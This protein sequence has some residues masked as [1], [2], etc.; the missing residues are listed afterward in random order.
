[1]LFSVTFHPWWRDS[2]GPLDVVLYRSMVQV[3]ARFLLAKHR[4]FVHEMFLDGLMNEKVRPAAANPVVSRAPRPP[5]P[6]AKR[7]AAVSCAYPD[8]QLYRIPRLLAGERQGCR[9]PARPFTR[10]HAASAI[11]V[12]GGR[13][14]D[15]AACACAGRH[16]PA[17]VARWRGFSWAGGWCCFSSRPPARA[18]PSVE[19]KPLVNRIW[20]LLATHECR[21]CRDFLYSMAILSICRRNFSSK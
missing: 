6:R 11:R 5:P 10:P 9:G 12:R 8:A 21:T 13:A 14:P 4:E 7:A 18:A 17:V 2:R 20:V 1:M 16:A 3:A 15:V 19:M